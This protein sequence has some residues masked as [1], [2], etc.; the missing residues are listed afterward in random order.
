MEKFR[1]KSFAGRK[2]LEKGGVGIHVF[3]MKLYMDKNLYMDFLRSD[4]FD[5]VRFNMRKYGGDM[6]LRTNSIAWRCT[7]YI[8]EASTLKRKKCG[9]V[10]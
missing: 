3:N 9:S 10:K 5:Q 7:N 8:T 1:I 2:L 4:E 6:R